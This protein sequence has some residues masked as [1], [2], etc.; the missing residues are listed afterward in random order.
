MPKP[1]S[2]IFFLA[3][4]QRYFSFIDTFIETVKV[5]FLCTFPNRFLKEAISSSLFLECT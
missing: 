4:Y 5:V 2:T 1:A 3:N